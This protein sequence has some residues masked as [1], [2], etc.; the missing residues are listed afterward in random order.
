MLKGTNQMQ[1]RITLSEWQSRQLVQKYNI[2]VA[3][4]ELVK[5][6]EAA[7]KSAGQLGYPVVL[8]GNGAKFAHKSELG[9]VHLGLASEEEVRD[10]YKAIVKSAGDALEGVLVQSQVK[11]RREFVAGVTRDQVFG[12][13]AMFGLGGVLTEAL[14]AVAFRLVPVEEG[15]IDPMLAEF[16]GHK[17]LGDFRGE[18]AVS[19]QQLHQMVLG[20]SQMIQ[21]NPKIM[22]ID[23]NPVLADREGNILA[24]DALVVERKTVPEKIIRERVPRARIRPMFNPQSVAFIGASA[25][26]GKWGHMLPI[27]VI[28]GGFKGD[29]HL[30]NQKGGEIFGRKVH[31]DL[32]DVPGDIDLAVITV[33]AKFIPD[34]IPKMQEKNVKGVLV[35]SSGFSEV[36]SEGKEKEKELVKIFDDAGLI[37]IGPNTMGINNPHQ[38]FYC[39]GSQVRPVVGSTALLA[40]SGNMGTQ[41]MAFAAQQGLGIRAFV[42]SGNEAMITIEDYL[43]AFEDDE[44][45]ENIVLY[46]EGFKDAERFFRNARR[47]ATKKPILVLKGGRTAE[48]GKAAASHTGAMASDARLFSAAC[49]QAAV[50]E[51]N[52]PLDL[53]DM[54]A[55]FSC[56]PLPKGNRV[57]IVTLGG[58]WGVVATDLCVENGLEMAQ[59]DQDII[60][61]INPLLPPFWSHANPVDIVGQIDVSISMKVTEALAAWDGCDM[62]LNLGIVGQDQ[63]MHWMRESVEK[64]D[65]T[66][67]KQTLDSIEEVFK[68]AEPMYIDHVIRTMEKYE[69]PIVGVKLLEGHDG[70]SLFSLDG[71]KYRGLFFPTPERA[72]STLGR[73]YD[74]ARARS[75][76]LD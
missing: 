11:A 64:A 50:I 51:L 30:V 66:T 43:E 73:F 68:N 19:R 21:D 47:I 29:I 49:R 48:G 75:I 45:T 14:Q 2:P 22:E 56:L 59:L 57:A 36:G 28:S 20:L 39:T 60:E 35:I 17:L 5:D 24:V 42:G 58:G 18:K 15:D 52:R 71:H 72:V 16:P 33:P 55:A 62:V 6:E 76:N 63:F 53:L 46:L 1:D 65:P 40:Q 31:T 10:A 67:D 3:A 54:S 37:M 13:V 7:V 12:P 38:S 25:Q 4:A 23:L 44:N 32:S 27:N 9:L 8:K 69:K 41:I 61:K 26:M 34:L 70:K 74:Y